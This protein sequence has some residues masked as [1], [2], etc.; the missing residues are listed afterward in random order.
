MELTLFDGRT[1]KNQVDLYPRLSGSSMVVVA[2]GAYA[3][4]SPLWF[5]GPE[6]LP[7]VHHMGRLLCDGI[8]FHIAEFVVWCGGFGLFSVYFCGI[9]V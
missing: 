6:C 7:L 3:S 5:A 9:L 4:R 2:S 8:I 1:S